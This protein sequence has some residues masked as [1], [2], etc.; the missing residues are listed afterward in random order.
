MATEPSQGSR[1]TL[2][3]TCHEG[4]E[5]RGGPFQV[6]VSFQNNDL[7]MRGGGNRPKTPFSTI[8]RLMLALHAWAAKVPGQKGES[9]CSRLSA[10]HCTDP[11]HLFSNRNQTDAIA[12]QSDS[13]R[14]DL[15]EYIHEFLRLGEKPGMG[16]GH[17]VYRDEITNDR[18]VKI[19]NCRSQSIQHRFDYVRAFAG[20][21]QRV[22]HDDMGI[23]P[24]V[25]Y[26]RV[27]VFSPNSLKP[28]ADDVFVHHEI[29]PFAGFSNRNDPGNAE[30]SK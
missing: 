23:C 27:V 9:P 14:R 18:E 4:E 8:Q 29:F 12:F 30:P 16:G 2:Q 19:G 17:L 3:A 15:E 6:R 10:K 24:P 5:R 13:L 25:N 21:M 22:L 7:E 11:V 20:I 26:P 1:K 28:L